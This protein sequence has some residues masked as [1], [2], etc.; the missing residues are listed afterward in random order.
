MMLKF[1]R[2]GLFSLLALWVTT[3]ARATRDQ[4][5]GRDLDDSDAIFVARTTAP[6]RPP[7]TTARPPAT[8]ARPPVTT[9]R[10]PG[11]TRPPIQYQCG[12]CLITAELITPLLG[13]S[14]VRR[15]LIPSLTSVHRFVQM[16]IHALT[17]IGRSQGNCSGAMRAHRPIP[18]S[19]DRPGGKNR[20]NIAIFLIAAIIAI[21]ADKS[22]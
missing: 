14:I 12:V 10:P 2:L 19:W 15:L 3:S 18:Y 7:A 11:T 9:A 16:Y 5:D 17:C 22:R 6:P 1:N 4:T 13:F 8:T 21:I 20:D